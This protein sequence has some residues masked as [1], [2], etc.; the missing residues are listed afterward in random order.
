KILKQK[1]Q[2]SQQFII[3]AQLI[4]IKIKFSILNQYFY[5]IL[6]VLFVSHT[7][8]IE[9]LQKEFGKQLVKSLGI[10]Y[11]MNNKSI[12]Q[13]ILKIVTQETFER[14]RIIFQAQNYSLSQQN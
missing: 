1:L 9:Y 3:I 4:Q 10:R 8:I 5:Y 13:L 12:N 2:I 14:S 6:G 11:Q 7:N